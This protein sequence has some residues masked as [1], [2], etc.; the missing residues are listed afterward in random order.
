MPA[1][2]IV[3]NEEL[4]CWALGKSLQTAGWRVRCACSAELALARLR[5]EAVDVLVSDVSLPGMDGFALLERV[6]E[7]WPGCRC[8]VITASWDDAVRARAME[9]GAVAALPK[10]LDLEAFKRTLAAV[11]S[12]GREGGT[13]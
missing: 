12:R 7:G 4:T 1:L 13:R 2:L 10:P 6:R 3:D 5:E 9:L 8:F 11:A